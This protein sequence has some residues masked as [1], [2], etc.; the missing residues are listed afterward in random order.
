MDH[1]SRLVTRD[2][3]LLFMSARNVPPGP[4]IVT[5]MNDTPTHLP[6][7]A[8]NFGVMPTVQKYGRYCYSASG[9]DSSSSYKAS[10]S[11]TDA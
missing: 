7:P 2:T 1:A 8:T 6:I 4:V 11:S 3:R 10:S 5:T 9:S